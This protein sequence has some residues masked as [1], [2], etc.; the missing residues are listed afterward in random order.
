MEGQKILV[1]NLAVS[2]DTLRENVNEANKI[3][4]DIGK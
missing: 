1:G 2:L 4:S 3:L